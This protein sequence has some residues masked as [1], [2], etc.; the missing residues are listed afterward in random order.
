M[1]QALRAR[2]RGRE[3]QFEIELAGASHALAAAQVELVRARLGEQRAHHLAQH[4]SLTSLPNRDSFST[5]LNHALLGR[6]TETST[7][8]VLFIDLDGFKAI[9]GRHGHGTGDELLRIV[10]SRKH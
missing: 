3:R 2:Q 8:A 1:L 6:G 7:L 9:N 5:R 4:D 10:A